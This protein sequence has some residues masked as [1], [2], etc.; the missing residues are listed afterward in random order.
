[1]NASCTDTV[2]SFTCQCNVGFTGSGVTCIGTTLYLS[3]L[4]YLFIINFVY[5]F[6][7]CVNFLV[8]HLVFSDIQGVLI[9]FYIV[10]NLHVPNLTV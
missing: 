6:I 7:Y 5:L 3:I 2:G 8:K 4:K 9:Y 1:M 10:E